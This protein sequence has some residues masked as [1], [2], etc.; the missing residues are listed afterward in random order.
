VVEDFD[1]V[2]RAVDAEDRNS[3]HHGNVVVHV[4]EDEEL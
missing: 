3:H 4:R 2:Q 1:V